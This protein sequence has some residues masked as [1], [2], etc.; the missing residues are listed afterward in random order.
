MV[1]NPYSDSLFKKLGFETVN[2]LDL[3][4]LGAKYK[5]QRPLDIDNMNGKTTTYAMVKQGL[6]SPMKGIE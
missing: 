2:V 3:T 5:G 4:K 1:S 6:K